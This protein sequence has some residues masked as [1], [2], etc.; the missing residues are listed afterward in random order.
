MG[1]V[2]DLDRALS[3]RTLGSGR[4]QRH[5]SQQRARVG[6]RCVT[7]EYLWRT[8]LDDAA[9]KNYGH[10]IAKMVDD[11]QVVA[12]EQVRYAK[13]L[14]QIL[15][16]IQYLGLHRDI[17]RAYRL[18]GHDEFGARNQSARNRNTLALA[19]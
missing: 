18:I 4:Q 19:A 9:L 3:R 14:L 13:L 11:R 12:D 10:F 8:L 7:E 5:C 16:Q 15:H 17:Q 2:R 1:D 6:V